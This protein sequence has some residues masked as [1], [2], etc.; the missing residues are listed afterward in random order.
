VEIDVPR[1]IRLIRQGNFADAFGVT[2]VEL[3]FDTKSERGQD[4]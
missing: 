2:P 3:Q 1:Y 4:G